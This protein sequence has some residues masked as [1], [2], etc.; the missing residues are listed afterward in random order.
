MNS[1]FPQ[2]RWS[3]MRSMTSGTKFL[4]L[5]HSASVNGDPAPTKMS[6]NIKLL[7]PFNHGKL[8]AAHNDLKA[9]FALTK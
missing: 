7:S 5:Q 6:I 8:Q 2:P 4:N 1:L 9:A 3:K